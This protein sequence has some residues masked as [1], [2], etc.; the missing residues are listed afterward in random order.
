[1]VRRVLAV[2]I[3]AASVWGAAAAFGSNAAAAAPRHGTLSSTEYKQL[4]QVLAGINHALAGKKVNWRAADAACRKAGTTTTLLKTQRKSCLA[5]L[6]TIEALLNFVT[7][8]PRCEAA[9]AATST[10]GT[11]TTGTTTTGTTTAGTTTTGGVSGADLQLV[12]C[13]NPEYKALSRA[14]STMYPTDSA[15]RRQALTRGFSGVCLATLVDTSAELRHE[16]NF[17]FTAK[18]LAADAALLTKVSRGQAPASDVNA[19]QVVDDASAFEQ[20]A[21]AWLNQ[22]SPQNLSV[23]AHQV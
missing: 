4:S 22:K 2:A 1:M 21:R 15:A 3:S 23:C 8:Q 18:H 14:A 20:S 12:V 19:T 13:L 16:E 5:D 9:A 10:T 6:T 17:A 7:D 11:T